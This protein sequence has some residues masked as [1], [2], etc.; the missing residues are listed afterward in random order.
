VDLLVFTGGIGEND[1][2]ARAAICEG[3]DKLGIPI[4]AARVMPPKE[5]EQI[6]WH[7]WQLRQRS[8]L[9][10]LAHAGNRE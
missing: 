9:G 1:A 10:G 2:V 5:E 7:C 8:R 6:A 3:L 4:G